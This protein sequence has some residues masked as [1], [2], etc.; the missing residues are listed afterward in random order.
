MSRNHE[1]PPS[2]NDSV[3]YGLSAILKSRRGKEQVL[4]KALVDIVEH[5]NNYEPG[6]IE[7]I[8]WV[9]TSPTLPFHDLRALHQPRSHGCAQQV[10]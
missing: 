3:M 9:E 2:E 6:T 7:D 8:M 1:L 4:E 10:S 5:V